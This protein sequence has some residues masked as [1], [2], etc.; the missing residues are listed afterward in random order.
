MKT[1]TRRVRKTTTAICQEVVYRQSPE[2]VWRA[3]TEAG[4]VSRWLLPVSRDIVPRAGHRFDF[5]PREGGRIACEVIEAEAEK[6]LSYSWQAAPEQPETRVTWTL[7]PTESGG[8]HL[9]L[10]HD[11]PSTAPLLLAASGWTA[12]MRACLGGA[13]DILPSRSSSRR[14]HR[15][16]NTATLSSRGDVLCLL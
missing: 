2:K 7:T 8:T 9:R 13:E 11:G 16:R 1:R 5:T 12:R 14:H 10:E 15:R 4:L 3:L 6:R